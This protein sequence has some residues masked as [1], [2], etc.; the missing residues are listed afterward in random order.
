MSSGDDFLFIRCISEFMAYSL[1]I[2]IIF[3]GAF[4]EIDNLAAAIAVT[5]ISAMSFCVLML[6]RLLRDHL[7]AS[8]HQK[9]KQH[10]ENK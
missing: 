7:Q 1:L 4:L 2:A 5:C 6:A 8:E 3:L 9:N 10:N